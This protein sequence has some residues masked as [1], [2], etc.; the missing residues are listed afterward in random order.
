M[1]QFFRLTGWVQYGVVPPGSGLPKLPIPAKAPEKAVQKVILLLVLHLIRSRPTGFVSQREIQAV[2]NRAG[3]D[4]IQTHLHSLRIGRFLA[5]KAGRKG[6]PGADEYR[7][8]A[9]LN[10][11]EWEMLARRL[12]G[13][14]GICKG[15]LHRPAF[16]TGFLGHNGMFVLGALRRSRRP[17]S[18]AEIHRYLSFL[19]GD[20]GT[21]RS[22]LKL[23]Q[24]FGLVEKIGSLWSIAAKFDELLR[25]YEKRYGPASRRERVKVR[26]RREREDNKKRLLGCTLT[27][28]QEVELRERATCIRCRRTN[29]ECINAESANLTIEHFPPR[30]WLKHWGIPDHLHFH[31]LICPSENAKYGGY[32]TGSHP[33]QLDKFIRVAVR[34]TDDIETIVKAKI[35]IE[36][37]RFYRHID[38]GDKKAAE[39]SGTRT[40]SLWYGLIHETR[41]AL[42][43]DLDGNVQDITSSRAKKNQRRR[44]RGQTSRT[45]YHAGRS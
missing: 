35:E 33:P 13:P 37:R 12:F 44:Q 3:R 6:L 40:A 20:E 30:T 14:S 2:L 5:R 38:N 17:L 23:A 28:Q 32:I 41:A 26:H 16:G 18:V 15:L 11:E 45:R 25:E 39:L 27:P 21:V 29:E 22:R 9:R 10:Q 42:V 43:T 1:D 34:T 4:P 24:K 8:G 36:V 7:P 19:I 31:F